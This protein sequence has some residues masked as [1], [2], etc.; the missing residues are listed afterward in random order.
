M[1][2]IEVHLVKINDDIDYNIIN[3]LVKLV[4][5]EKANKIYKYKFKKDQIRSVAADVLIR[6]IIS[7]KLD[8]KNTDIEFGYNK[9]SKPFPKN[10]DLHFNI[11]HSG[12]YV[13]GLV[14]KEPVGI[15]IELIKPL[16]DKMSIAKSFFSVDEFKWLEN[17]T[18]GKRLKEFYK[19]W[20]AKESYVK[21]LGIG[22][23][24]KSKSFTTHFSDVI[25]IYD[26]ENHKESYCY[27][28]LIEDKY[29][30]TVCLQKKVDNIEFKT[31][32]LLDKYM[33]YSKLK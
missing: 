11:S 13:V 14:D 6:D 22:L 27:Q 26:E 12:D 7:N 25:T 17:K 10:L 28:K 29:Y 15:D 18:E 5:K 9:Y 4:S 8:I 2:K 23:S 33:K 16:K 31:S 32:N 21:L 19:I 30:L 20:T 1:R 3:T 24:K